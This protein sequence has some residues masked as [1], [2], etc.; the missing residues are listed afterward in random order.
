MSAAP[1]IFIVY[2]GESPCPDAGTVRSL[3]GTGQR[4][5]QKSEPGSKSEAVDQGWPR[6]VVDNSAVGKPYDAFAVRRDFPERWQ[7]YIRA[8]FRNLGHV[9]KVF[10]VC[11]RTARKWWD[12][13]TGVNGGFI[14][15]AVN[16]HPV[17]APRM[18]FAAA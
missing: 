4:S 15:I 2:G 1:Q 12:G 8:N 11:E 6:L 18:L 3:V 14:A 10:G 16:E 9:Q 17:A 13:E 7:A 5:A